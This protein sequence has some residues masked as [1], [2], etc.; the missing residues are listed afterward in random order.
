L[1]QAGLVVSPKR[2]RFPITD[3][4]RKLLLEKPPKIDIGFLERFE[5]FRAFR[6]IA[7]KPD[8]QSHSDAP[9]GDVVGAN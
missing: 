2:G 6:N 8:A 4:G 9:T 5:S 7:K 1:E 3:V